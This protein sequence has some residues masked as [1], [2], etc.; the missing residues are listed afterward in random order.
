MIWESSHSWNT[1][2]NKTRKKKI[3][4]KNHITGFE[5]GMNPHYLMKSEL[6]CDSTIVWLEYMQG[7][8][9]KISCHTM[10]SKKL[11]I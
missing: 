8:T 2:K 5:Q 10:G 7:G 1:D 3:G 6:F 11:L 9:V 4:E